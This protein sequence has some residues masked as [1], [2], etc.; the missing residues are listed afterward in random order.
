MTSTFYNTTSIIDFS[1]KLLFGGKIITCLR[2][3]LRS[4]STSTRVKLDR[5]FFWYFFRKGQLPPFRNPH[6]AQ[7]K[8]TFLLWTCDFNYV[9]T[10]SLWKYEQ[11]SDAPLQ[12]SEFTISL[13]WQLN[14]PMC[15][16]TFFERIGFPMIQNID[17]LYRYWEGYSW[18][19]YLTWLFASMSSPVSPSSLL[20]RT[21]VIFFCYK[22]N[23]MEY[24][25]ILKPWRSA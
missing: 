24:E 3:K 5:I 7:W 10:R 1:Q 16:W 23:N 12:R 14:L 18:E 15:V 22:S 20:L 25:Y 9:F 8:R 11:P 17:G 2:F 6:A 13:S 19:R 4:I 21:A